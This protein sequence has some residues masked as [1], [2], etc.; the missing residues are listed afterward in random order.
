MIAATNRISLSHCAPEVGAD[1][2][3]VVPIVDELELEPIEVGVDPV[4]DSG[5]RTLTDQSG[6]H[7]GACDA[8]ALNDDLVDAAHDL[9]ALVGDEIA[10]QCAKHRVAI[11]AACVAITVSEN[12][13]EETDVAC[14]GCLFRVRDQGAD[15]G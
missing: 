10:A 2:L 7:D 15:P 8:V 11:V 12:T 14:L 5:V 4:D 1:D 13:A 9:D 6:M 3:P